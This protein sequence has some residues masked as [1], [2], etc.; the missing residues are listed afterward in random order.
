MLKD[1]RVV[2][3]ITN[4][5]EIARFQADAQTLDG[6]VSAV[7]KQARL[8]GDL[9]NLS[10]GTQA[11]AI[12]A[13]QL[14]EGDALGHPGQPAVDF[15]FAYDGHGGPLEGRQTKIT[16]MNGSFILEGSRDNGHS[17]VEVVGAFGDE[18]VAGRI[19]TIWKAGHL[20]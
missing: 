3:R 9:E 6:R 20:G 4:L 7:V 10:T 13:E 15:H 14:G 5:V 1:Y 11:P 12:V 18:S 2:A 17:Y 8:Q 19:A 16:P